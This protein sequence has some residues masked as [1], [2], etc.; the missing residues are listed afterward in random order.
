MDGHLTADLTAIADWA[1]HDISRWSTKMSN[2]RFGHLSAV[3]LSSCPLL[4]GL[5]PGFAVGL[6]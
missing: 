3:I 5:A 1:R 2:F 4:A 6:Y